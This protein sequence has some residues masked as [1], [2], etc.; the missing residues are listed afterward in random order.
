MISCAATSRLI[1]G[2]IL[3]GFSFYAGFQI[4]EAPKI[5]ERTEFVYITQPIDLPT[6]A[7]K[8]RGA[9][10]NIFAAALPASVLIASGGKGK[11]RHP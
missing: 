1:C 6:K 8:Y 5:I 10:A 9:E 4:R 11:L 7:A 2:A 3:C